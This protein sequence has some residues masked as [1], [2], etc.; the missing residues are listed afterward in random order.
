[1]SAKEALLK[2]AR[3]KNAGLQNQILGSNEMAI[4]IDVEAIQPNPFQPRRY[5]DEEKIVDLSESIKAEGLIEPIIVIDNGSSYTLVVGERRLRAVKMAGM[6]QI[7]A[8]VRTLD[9][10]Q[11]RLQAMIENTHRDDLT[12]Y[13]LAIG[14]QQIRD[15]LGDI[16]D[17][18]LAA[19]VKVSYS[20][21]RSIMSILK[22][23]EAILDDLS[24]NKTSIPLQVL[25][26]LS[27]V[28]HDI[29]NTLYADILT[30]GFNRAQAM[31]FIDEKTKGVK[32]HAD[33]K[34]VNIWGSFK[35]SK[36]KT[37]LQINRKQIPDQNLKRIDEL[38]KEIQELVE[39]KGN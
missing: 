20:H 14:Y 1:M 36:T 24:E 28:Q 21:L 11:M 34:S 2:K 38:L 26:R 12:L 18:A 31:A 35:N 13:E 4:L 17:K 39:N 15:A 10:N 16:D 33:K 37:V 27:T 32:T 3:E 5:F 19:A 22:L 30:R 7:K 9:E 6:Q 8:I 23:P 29:A 25:E